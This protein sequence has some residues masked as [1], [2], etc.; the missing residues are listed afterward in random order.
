MRYSIFLL[1][2]FNIFPN[3]L[4]V[5]LDVQTY[6]FIEIVLCTF[7]WLWEQQKRK[8]NILVSELRPKQFIM[9]YKEEWKRQT[10][11]NGQL[12]T[13]EC[14]NL[15]NDW[16]EHSN[17]KIRTNYTFEIFLKRTSKNSH[18]IYVVK[19]QNAVKLKQC[20]KISLLF[21]K[22]IAIFIVRFTDI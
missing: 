22:S 4:Q 19:L 6:M 17:C 5:I 9:F 8:T 16:K 1:N 18:F 13:Y 20:S 2:T 21:N 14:Q 11:K 3:T 12:A 15:E 7:M 10:S